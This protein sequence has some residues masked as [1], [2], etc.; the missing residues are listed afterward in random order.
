MSTAA[1]VHRNCPL[2][3][4][5]EGLAELAVLGELVGSEVLAELE[6]LGVPEAT[7]GSTTRNIEGAHR[8]ATGLPQTG[9]AAPLAETH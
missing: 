6:V 3:A 4:V 1:T 5:L 9:L 2:V 8:I 7:G